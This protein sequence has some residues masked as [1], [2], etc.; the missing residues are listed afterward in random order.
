[1]SLIRTKRQAQEPIQAILLTEQQPLTQAEKT[2]LKRIAKK[3][4]RSMA[5]VYA[6]LV[7][8]LILAWLNGPTSGRR[9]YSRNSS[10]EAIEERWERFRVVAPI[11]IS[12]FFTVLTIYFYRY[13][14]QTV[15][16]F[17]RDIKVG[18]KDLVYFEPSVYKTPFFESYYIQTILRKRPTIKVSKEF[19]EQVHPES[20]ACLAI[21]QHAKFVF[22]LKVDDQQI[23]F[24]ERNISMD[25]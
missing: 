19:Y 13:F 9:A 23:N 12:F 7:G 1:M 17:L 8:V 20:R 16:R 6:V 24:D 4:L 22:Y 25:D 3:K 15:Y 10:P 21:S 18:K 11:V 14:R 2:I 5:L